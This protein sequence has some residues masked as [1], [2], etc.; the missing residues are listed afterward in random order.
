MAIIINVYYANIV[1]AFKIIPIVVIRNYV[2]ITIWI[3]FNII[4]AYLKKIWLRKLGRL[5][6]LSH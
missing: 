5:R 3:L 2:V 6:N 1:L 4:S